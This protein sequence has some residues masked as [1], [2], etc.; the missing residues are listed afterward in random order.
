MTAPSDHAD[1]IQLICSVNEVYLLRTLSANTPD[2]SSHATLISLS[3]ATCP[4]KASPNP[5]LGVE[6]NPFFLSILHPQTSRGLRLCCASIGPVNAFR[7]DI[8]RAALR[9][10]LPGSCKASAWTKA[11]TWFWKSIEETKGRKTTRGKQWIKTGGLDF[12]LSLRDNMGKT[13]HAAEAP[14]ADVQL[15]RTVLLYWLGDLLK[16]HRF[17]SPRL[18]HILHTGRILDPG[19]LMP[20]FD[21]ELDDDGF[22]FLCGIESAVTEDD[23]LLVQC[24]ND[25]FEYTSQLL[26]ETRKEVEQN[27]WTRLVGLRIARQYVLRD[28]TFYFSPYSILPGAIETLCRPPSTV[29]NAGTLG[30]RPLDHLARLLTFPIEDYFLV[31]DSSITTDSAL[32]RLLLA[33]FKASP[34]DLAGITNEPEDFPSETTMT[35]CIRR[36]KSR[37]YRVK[38]ET[39]PIV[40]Q[41]IKTVFLLDFGNWRLR[42]L[43]RLCSCFSTSR[44]MSRAQAAWVALNTSTPLISAESIDPTEWTQDTPINS[45]I[46]WFALNF[47]EK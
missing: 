40:A 4:T 43:R 46:S 16:R 7:P 25:L 42:Q 5:A 12:W 23:R 27:A 34:Q 32:R 35:Q 26:H 22:R 1:E 44:I 3:C 31:Y 39:N 29:I 30:E 14:A 9:V 24:Y 6:P 41:G 38:A 17:P 18:R 13:L 37:V 21:T 45:V 33:Q 11:L 8:L 28:R 36:V 10:F 19:T 47:T 2:E 20:A 15:G